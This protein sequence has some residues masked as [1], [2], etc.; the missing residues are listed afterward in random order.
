MEL[1]KKEIMDLEVVHE[2]TPL[3]EL[4]A[5]INKSVAIIKKQNAII[6]RTDSKLYNFSNA[7]KLLGVNRLTVSKAISKKE[8]NTTD[9]GGRKWI[10][11]S[12]IDRIN[13]K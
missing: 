5:Q 11:Q 2:L 1:T 10:P 9:F 13:L 8:I 3:E 7:A 6:N 12:E 4:E